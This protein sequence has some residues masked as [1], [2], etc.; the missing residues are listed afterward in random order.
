MQ[1]DVQVAA[2]DARDPVAGAESATSAISWAA[3]IAGAVVASALS[4]SR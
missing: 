1:A 4:L 2:L 3:I